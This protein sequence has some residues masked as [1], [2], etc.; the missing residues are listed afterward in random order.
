MNLILCYIRTDL[1]PFIVTYFIPAPMFSFAIITYNPPDGLRQHL[2]ELVHGEVGREGCI[3]AIP[4]RPAVY[5][6]T[7]LPL[8]FLQCS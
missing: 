6:H 3:A 7:V 4:P 8:V 5:G 1:F 2:G